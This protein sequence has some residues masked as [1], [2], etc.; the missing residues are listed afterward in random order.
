MRSSAKKKVFPVDGEKSAAEWGQ[1]FGQGFRQRMYRS[2]GGIR[3][4]IGAKGQGNLDQ[5]DRK[6]KQKQD[7]VSIATEVTRVFVPYERTK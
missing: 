2:T 4:R 3:D 1:K 5:A 6:K 7:T